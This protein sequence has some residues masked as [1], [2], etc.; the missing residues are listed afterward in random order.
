LTEKLDESLEV[1]PEQLSR[2]TSDTVYTTERSNT[3]NSNGGESFLLAPPIPGP[4]PITATGD[5]AASTFSFEPETGG[6]TSILARNV[7]VKYYKPSNTTKYSATQRYTD[8]VDDDDSQLDEALNIDDGDS[9]ID[10]YHQDGSI[11]MWAGSVEDYH[12]SFPRQNA[13]PMS[14]SDALG[15]SRVLPL[16]PTNSAVVQAAACLNPESERSID[17]TSSIAPDLED[18]TNFPT[19]CIG[20]PRT[21]LDG[22]A[23]SYYFSSADYDQ[24]DDILGLLD[25]VNSVPDDCQPVD[26]FRSKSLPMHLETSSTLT[27]R[28][29]SVIRLLDNTITLYSKPAF[30]EQNLCNSGPTD[31]VDVGDLPLPQ[32]LP[33]HHKTTRAL[34]PISERSLDSD[35]SLH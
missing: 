27:R 33:H 31:D 22:Q 16:E 15:L 8:E 29:S 7:S 10:E 35:Y 20:G 4:T 28:H 5:D 30:S 14:L 34:T 32:G 25:E 2:S 18:T 11:A 24:D 23:L 9:I 26:L 21:P 12:N 13:P 3:G 1:T 17:T 6:S 19:P